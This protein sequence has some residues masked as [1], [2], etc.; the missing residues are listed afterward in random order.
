MHQKV[1]NGITVTALDL[2]E[3]FVILGSKLCEITYGAVQDT[4]EMLQES[5]R[6]GLKSSFLEELALGGADNLGKVSLV[7]SS[8]AVD[9]DFEKTVL[10]WYDEA[11]SNIEDNFVETDSEDEVES[12]RNTTMTF[13]LKMM[14][15]KNV[16]I[17]VKEF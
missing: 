10:Q 16:H 8:S 6:S 17:N 3:Y 14:S 15:L 2:S 12:C 1:V 11:E 4:S 7:D 13:L 9:P 5:N